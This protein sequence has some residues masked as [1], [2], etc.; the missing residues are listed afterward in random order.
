MNVQTVARP[1]GRLI[2]PE[3]GEIQ[4]GLINSKLSPLLSRDGATTALDMRPFIPARPGE[5][6]LF[7]SNSISPCP[8][9]QGSIG[10]KSE[11]ASTRQLAI[12]E[13]FRGQS[14]WCC[15]SPAA[16][17]LSPTAAH[18]HVFLDSGAI[19]GTTAGRADA[20]MFVEFRGQSVSEPDAER[21]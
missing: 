19:T 10:Q 16:S 3:T 4:E 11:R 6:N 7:P 17:S 21:R 13:R 8:I 18:R 12:H 1:D 20:L 9:K 15:C 14:A 2:E 5:Q